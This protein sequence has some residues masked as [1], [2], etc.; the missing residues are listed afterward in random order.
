MGTAACGGSSGTATSLPTFAVIGAQRAG[1]TALYSWLRAHPDVFIPEVK[2]LNFFFREG[3][4]D[5]GVPWYRSLFEGAGAARHRGDVSPSYSM[6]PLASGS[7]EL[8]R[9]VV[10]EVKLIYLVRHP[11]ERMRAAY[12]LMTSIG[13]ETRPIDQ[14]L[15]RDSLYVSTSQ[16]AMQLEQFL[17]RFDREQILVVRSED[18]RERRGPTLG[19]ILSFLDLGSDWRPDDL[20]T[21]HNP[22]AAK[23]RPRRRA[24]RALGVAHRLGMRAVSA[25]GLADH[26]WTSRPLTE[27]ELTIDPDLGA[28]LQQWLRPD[29]LRLRALLGEDFDTWGL[30]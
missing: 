15:R 14:A 28:V 21:E 27:A 6:F 12:A 13:Q 16:Y 24:V 4:W 22:T 25:E 17:E 18:L 20:A 10:P 2:E 26:W 8:M 5:R 1:T 7:P 29:L 11:I 9:R 3:H 30:L 19:R 23:R